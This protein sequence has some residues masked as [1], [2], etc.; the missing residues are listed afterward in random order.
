M[1]AV[2]LSSKYTSTTTVKRSGG[3]VLES[4]SKTKVVF[5]PY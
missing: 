5:M 2:T 4:N 1:T 3:V